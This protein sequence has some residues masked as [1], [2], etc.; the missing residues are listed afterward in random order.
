LALLAKQVG[1]DRVT[2]RSLGEVTRST[3]TAGGA[4]VLVADPSDLARVV[5]EVFYDPRIRQESATVE[6]QN[7]TT[8]N[9]LARAAN[10]YFVQRGLSEATVSVSSTASAAQDETSILNYHGKTY[11][12]ERLA[13]WLGIPTSRVKTVRDGTT[14]AVDTPDI[15]VVLGR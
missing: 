5:S 14:L 6:I 1:L 10:S 12:A 7:G 3:V 11:T 15:V 2:M 9:G 8:R 13:D 4:D